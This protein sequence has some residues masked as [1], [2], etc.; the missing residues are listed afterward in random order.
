MKNGEK[1]KTQEERANAFAVFCGAQKCSECAMHVDLPYQCA[2]EWLELD[3][4]EERI[5]PC[6][7]CGNKCEV[8]MSYFEDDCVFIRCKNEDCTYLSGAA[9]TKAAAI[10]AHNRVAKAVM[11]AKEGESK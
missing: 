6:P 2:F 7:F 4:T 10:A 1:Y 9:D 11:A 8:L 5:E 3:A